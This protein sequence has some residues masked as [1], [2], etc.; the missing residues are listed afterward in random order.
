M[1]PPA[2]PA[3]NALV[4]YAADLARTERFYRDVLGIDLVPVEGDEDHP[5]M[6]TADVGALSLVFVENAEDRPGASPVVV[7]GLDGG[8]EDAVDAL[9][10]QNVEIVAPVSEAPG[11]GLTVDFAD[12]DRHTLSYYQPVGRPT[13]LA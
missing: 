9:V 4:F 13:R 8:I 12:P 11:G 2:S 3:V 7:F 6:L 5:S 10:R 1:Q